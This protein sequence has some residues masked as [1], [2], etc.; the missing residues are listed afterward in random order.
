M[1]ASVV[2]VAVV[3]EWSSDAVGDLGH[4]PPLSDPDDTDALRLGLLDGGA[5]ADSVCPGSPDCAAGPPNPGD[6]CPWYT[7]GPGCCTGVLNGVRL[8]CPVCACTCT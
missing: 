6:I 8:Y 1:V 7:G 5:P 3:D 4:D 2:T